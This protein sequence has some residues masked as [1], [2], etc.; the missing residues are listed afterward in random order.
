MSV[1]APIKAMPKISEHIT[2]VLKAA[3]Q[4]CQNNTSGTFVGFIA[5]SW[6]NVGIDGNQCGRA[7]HACPLS[8]SL[9]PAQPDGLVFSLRRLA[10]SAAFSQG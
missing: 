9:R 7:L 10:L 6:R 8:R 2:T 3:D 1:R 5:V 4:R